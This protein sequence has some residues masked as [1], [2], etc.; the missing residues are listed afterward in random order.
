MIRKIF[1]ALF[2]ST[3]AIVGLVPASPATAAGTFSPAV[4]F[5]EQEIARTIIPLND[6][7]AIYIWS[8]FQSPT[9]AL[10]SGIMNSDGTMTNVTVIRETT[11][12]VFGFQGDSSWV[13]MSDGT[14]ALTWATTIDNG[15]V[16]YSVVEVAY[17]ENGID[18]SDSVVALAARTADNASFVG[19]GYRSVRAALDFR[20]VLAV[21]ATYSDGT[22]SR[23]LVATTTNGLTW[24]PET[25]LD[26]LDDGYMYGTAI[27]SLTTGGFLISWAQ[28]YGEAMTR[29][30]SRMPSSSINYWTK[31]QSIAVGDW[32]S[33]SIPTFVKS[34]PNL[35]TLLYARGGGSNDQ[36]VMATTFNNS[37]KA[38][39]TPQTV[40][41]SPAGWLTSALI[42]VQSETNRGSVLFSFSDDGQTSARVQM[43][44]VENGIAT[45]PSVIDSAS[46]QDFQLSG[47]K[48]NPDGSI[49]F[50][51][52]PL[53]GD[54]RIST[55]RASS[56]LETV[57]PPLSG[58][59]SVNQTVGFS[60][61]GNVFLST[62][63]SGAYRQI[64]YVQASAPTHTG[65]P[66]VRGTAK[67][68]AKLTAGSLIF[69]SISGIGANTYQWY[70]CTRAVPVNTRVLPAGCAA[71]AK[72]TSSK[73]T[74]TSKQKGKYI[75]VAVKNTNAVGTTMIF[76]PVATK[77]K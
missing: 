42:G 76:A 7:Q 58:D 3:L 24:T 33:G 61:N 50:V 48:A 28:T 22:A 46:E 12:G 36:I 4:T 44:H 40:F 41:D 16:S 75:T 27:T 10:K 1:S 63:R 37:L 55:W 5:T 62:L 71:I 68:G 23:M 65:T 6:N 13:R 38:W 59:Q 31:A 25:A 66:S 14:I 15:D 45:T 67:K 8:T 70:A 30:V 77:S 9:A 29:K 39:S 64:V 56:D 52:K 32:A 2:V 53:N 49:T 47:A 21:S 26:Y 35:Y 11:N 34:G 74:V 20:G 17:T 72:A 19:T 18:W 54:I 73:F 43:F 69:N 57:N 60:A 51:T